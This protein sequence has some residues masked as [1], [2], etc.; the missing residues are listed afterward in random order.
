MRT[1]VVSGEALI[2][3][4]FLARPGA[5]SL[6]TDGTFDMWAGLIKRYWQVSVFKETPANTPYSFLLLG[7][8]SFFFFL[9]IVVQWMIADT[10]NQLTLNMSLLAAGALLASYG[11]YTAAL[12]FAYRMPSRIVQTLTCL[13]SGHTIVHLFAFPLLLVTPWLV[14]TTI[15]QPLGLFIGV[16]YLILTL[17]LTIWQFMVTVHIYKH[18]LG[19]DSLPAVLASLGLLACNILIVSFWR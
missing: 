10:D 1:G 16:M 6:A 7:F 3:S 13:L 9:L 12:L 17:M 19:V 5:K 18:A 2:S 11:L 8:I 14:D 15:I 4:L